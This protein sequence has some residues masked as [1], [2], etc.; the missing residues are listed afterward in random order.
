MKHETA[1]KTWSKDPYSYLKTYLLYEQPGL[2]ILCTIKSNF[3]NFVFYLFNM[4]KFKLT[5]CVPLW[6]IDQNRHADR[7]FELNQPTNN[8]Y[9]LQLKTISARQQKSREFKRIHTKNRDQR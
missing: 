3:Y 5:V 1:W 8:I 2:F 4:Y 7:R 9:E 6:P